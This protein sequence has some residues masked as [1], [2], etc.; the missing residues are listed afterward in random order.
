MIREYDLIDAVQ[1]L[2]V[3]RTEKYIQHEVVKEFWTSV[4][5]IENST[6]KFAKFH[7][8][9][10][11]LYNAYLQISNI[12]HNLES[13]CTALEHP[14]S[15]YGKTKS[16]D[17]LKLIFKSSLLCQLPLNYSNVIKCFYET[18]LK[19]EEG[20]GS[21][22]CANECFICSLDTNICVCAQY[23]YEVNRYI[24]FI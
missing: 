7:M 1:D 19:Y 10:L 8:V 24:L 23:F 15:I 6:E 3:K 13:L 12:F 17:A 22:S 9:M 16:A 5:S 11:T 21:M 18:A 14:F 4:I 2:V 20:E